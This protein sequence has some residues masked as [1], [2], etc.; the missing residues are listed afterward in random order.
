MYR[1]FVCQSNDAQDSTVEITHCS[2][3]SKA[4]GWLKFD[5]QWML[6][7]SNAPF[8]LEVWA[9]SQHFIFEIRRE[10]VQMRIAQFT[11]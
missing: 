5:A 4:V 11:L 9:F 1:Q 10:S 7:D 8:L 2:P 6:D 3:E